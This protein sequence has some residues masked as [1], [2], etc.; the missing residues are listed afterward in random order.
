MWLWKHFL[1]ENLLH[2]HSF[3]CEQKSRQKQLKI[4]P[5]Q[6]FNNT[7]KSHRDSL[8]VCFQH[9]TVRSYGNTTHAV[10]YQRDNLCHIEAIVHGKRSIFE[11]LFSERTA[12]GARNL[13]N[14]TDRKKII[15]SWWKLDCF[16]VIFF[17]H[18]I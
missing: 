7:N 2:I 13:K 12:L 17:N 16:Q 18:F 9:V 5:N 3:I 11:E 1:C 15:L 10:V 14:K 8:P 4:D 6:R